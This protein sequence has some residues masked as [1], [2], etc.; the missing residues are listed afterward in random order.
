MLC[1]IIFVFV[2]YLEAF[3]VCV[4]DSTIDREGG[5]EVATGGNPTPFAICERECIFV[6]GKSVCECV[7]QPA[8]TDYRWP[9]QLS[10]T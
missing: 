4:Y 6:C 10:T 3:S 9:V 2:V 8:S 5:G 7:S 1:C